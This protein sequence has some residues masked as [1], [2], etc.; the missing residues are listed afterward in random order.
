[1]IARL[2]RGANDPK[3]AHEA[4]TDIRGTIFICIIGIAIISAW[5]KSQFG[6]A[7]QGDLATRVVHIGGRNVQVTVVDTPASRERGLSGRSGLASDEGMLFVFP[8]DG[9][10]GFWM[11][12]MRFPI[13]IVWLSGRGEVLDM[14]TSVSPASYPAVFEPKAPARFVLE[15]PAGFTDAYTVRIG[16]EV[17]F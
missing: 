17:K 13:D 11:K 2:F 14:R 4:H 7:A 3:T 9:K 10:Y 12:D 8:S 15:L 5:G 1:M 16:D 6:I